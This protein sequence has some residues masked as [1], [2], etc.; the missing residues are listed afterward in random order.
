MSSFGAYIIVRYDPTA[1]QEF[2]LTEPVTTLGREPINDVVLY[3]SEVS[4]EH[5]KISDLEGRFVLEDL[6]STNGT[7]LNHRRINVPAPL[8]NGDIIEMGDTVQ[9]TFHQPSDMG[10]GISFDPRAEP[11]VVETVVQDDRY[12]EPQYDTPQF[13]YTE[14]AEFPESLPE[15][16]QYS[17][18]PPPPPLPESMMDPAVAVFDPYEPIAESEDTRRRYTIGCSCLLL[19]AVGACA[20]TFVLLDQFASET[21]YCGPLEPVF[22]FLANL[23]GRALSC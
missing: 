11:A 13:P 4:R 7:F 18:P 10:A 23:L 19:L 12:R 16:G 15:Y 6:G 9:V 20:T 22:D 1:E 5:A 3:D 21:L 8:R 17:P 2:L 14:P